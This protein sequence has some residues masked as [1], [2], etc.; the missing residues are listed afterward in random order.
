M[1][2][3]WVIGAAILS[4][5]GATDEKDAAGG[6]ATNDGKAKV[7]SGIQEGYG[8][9]A[10]LV[11]DITGPARGKDPLC[12]VCENGNRP[13]VLILT[14]EVDREV[15]DLVR[16][17]DGLVKGRNDAGAF[18][19]LLDDRDEKASAAALRKLAA[20]TGATIPL[21]LSYEGE[22]TI[23]SYKLDP[24]VKHTVL[25]YR[26]KTVVKNFALERIPEAAI[27]E[28]TEAARKVMAEGGTEGG[29]GERS[30]KP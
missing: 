1:R 26:T 17:V 12:Y 8:T 24:R 9:P 11:T 21:T 19:V 20:D 13:V 15:A 29:T 5:V 6:K 18:L 23:K 14:R 3:A 10:F 25:I 16:A 7:L 4:L 28:I 22:K 2:A 30:R 27:R